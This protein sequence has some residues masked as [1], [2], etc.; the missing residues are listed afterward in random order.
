M[1]DKI[2]TLF[3]NSLKI[4]IRQDDLSNDFIEKIKNYIKR[5]KDKS[6]SK[7]I[8]IKLESS[9]KKLDKSLSSN[10]KKKLVKRTKSVDFQNEVILSIDEVK[11][12]Y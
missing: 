8:N 4:I 7:N 5:E 9:P 6:N 11:N 3:M 10:S 1:E 2:N 12:T